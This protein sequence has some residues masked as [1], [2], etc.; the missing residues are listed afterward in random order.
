[1]D[2][3]ER[4]RGSLAPPEHQR[5]PSSNRLRMPIGAA[6]VLSSTR[7]LHRSSSGTRSPAVP[8]NPP[9]TSRG[10]CS[11]RCARTPSAAIALP[12][13]SA[14]APMRARAWCH[15]EARVAAVR[16]AVHPQVAAAIGSPCCITLRPSSGAVQHTS[17]ATSPTA[18]GSERLPSTADLPHSQR[19]ETCPGVRV[20]RI[21][22]PEQHRSRA[23]PKTGQ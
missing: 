13:A 23:G 1:M 8:E 9:A 20:Q 18:S 22:C 11:P 2:G 17:T 21:V 5:S 4:L 7:S 16:I 10:L 3:L 19:S 6:G 15:A 12:A 14:F